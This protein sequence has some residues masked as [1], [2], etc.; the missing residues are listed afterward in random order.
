MLKKKLSHAHSAINI[1]HPCIICIPKRTLNN[2]YE[3]PLYKHVDGRTKFHAVSLVAT[4]QNI[5]Y[6]IYFLNFT[7]NQLFVI[8]ETHMAIYGSVKIRRNFLCIAKEDGCKPHN[9]RYASHNQMCQS[10]QSSYTCIYHHCQT[11]FF[12]QG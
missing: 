10:N 7:Q 9:K 1:I 12:R 11:R 8:L 4:C 3:T 2:E 5:F 6:D